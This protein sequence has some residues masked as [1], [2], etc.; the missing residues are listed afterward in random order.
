MVDHGSGIHQE[1][2]KLGPPK[3]RRTFTSFVLSTKKRLFGKME[4][5]DIMFQWI[6]QCLILQLQCVHLK[7]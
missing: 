5:V 6:M 1:E 3:R 7:D 2:S 4:V